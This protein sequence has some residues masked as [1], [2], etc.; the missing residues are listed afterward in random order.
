MPLDFAEGCEQR[1]AERFGPVEIAVVR[2]V[3]PE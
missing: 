1:L 3:H 2:A